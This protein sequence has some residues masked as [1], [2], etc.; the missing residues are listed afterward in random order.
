VMQSGE[1][2]DRDRWLA[3][4]RVREAAVVAN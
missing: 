3:N 1:A 4:R 2:F